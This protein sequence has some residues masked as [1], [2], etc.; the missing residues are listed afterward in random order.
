MTRIYSEWAGNPKG[1][2]EDITLCICEVFPAHEWV[3]R[4]CN[5][6]RGHGPGRLYCK[7]HARIVERNE[8]IIKEPKP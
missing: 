2:P 7:Q 5:R 1:V 6:K 8:K 4:Q 3:S